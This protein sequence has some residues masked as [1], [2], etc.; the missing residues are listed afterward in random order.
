MFMSPFIEHR[1]SVGSWETELFEDMSWCLYF[2]S[3]GIKTVI[4]S[5]K[6]SCFDHMVLASRFAI[7]KASDQLLLLKK[8][9]GNTKDDIR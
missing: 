3:N 5:G 1:I 2:N 7:Q 9:T 6:E 4:A 8:T